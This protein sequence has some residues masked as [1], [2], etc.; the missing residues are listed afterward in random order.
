VNPDNEVPERTLV[1]D[2]NGNYMYEYYFSSS[3]NDRVPYLMKMLCVI[4]T[5]QVVFA[6]CTITNYSKKKRTS[7]KI[8][9]AK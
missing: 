2:G 5:V 8:K 1:T 6:L 7:S 3:V 9:R 4:W